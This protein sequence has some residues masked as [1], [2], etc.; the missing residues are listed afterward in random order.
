MDTWT[1]IG[2]WVAVG[3]TLLIYSFLYKDNP[4]F[5]FGEHLY[6]GV[7]LGYVFIQA[8]FQTLKPKLWIPLVTPPENEAHQWSLILPVVMGLLVYARLFPKFAWLSRYTFAFIVGYGSGV[9][10]GPTVSG[11]ILQQIEGTFKPFLTWGN[12]SPFMKAS[13]VLV[14][15][16]VICTVTYFLFSIEH[17]GPIRIASRIGISFLMVSFGA[18]FGYTVMARMSLLVD[19]L[20]DLVKNA[21]A[22]SHRATW[23]CLALIVGGIVAW[24][25]TR[26]PKKEGESH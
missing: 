20:R 17:K 13:Q 24:E 26:P 6:L 10:L 21:S 7:S 18:A 23:V 5:K 22:E 11:S 2:V 9:G 14:L 3:L 15:I 8:I 12:L 19:R 4:F 25:L 1:L 16:G